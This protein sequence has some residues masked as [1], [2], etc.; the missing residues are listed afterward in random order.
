MLERDQIEREGE[1][2]EKDRSDCEE[3]KR[4]STILF[5]LN[6][7][8]LYRSQVASTLHPPPLPS[9]QAMS[10]PSPSSC[11]GTTPP[12]SPTSPQCLSS[13]S[14]GWERR[15]LPL[16]GALDLAHCIIQWRIQAFVHQR[17]RRG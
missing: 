13:A 17:M 4:H 2:E 16:F 6:L 10:L 9:T 11:Q 3:K 12:S 15:S 8:P 5:L 1:I 14:L 7:L